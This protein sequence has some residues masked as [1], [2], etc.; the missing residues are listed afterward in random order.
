MKYTSI[1]AVAAVAFATPA[2]AKSMADEQKDVRD[3]QAAVAK[4]DAAIAKQN[5]NI[6]VNRAEKEAAKA[7]GDKM[8]QA[9]QSVQIG[10]N[11]TAKE[12]KKAEK[13]AD[14]KILEHDKKDINEANMEDKSGSKHHATKHHASKHHASNSSARTSSNASRDT[15]Q[16]QENLRV[17]REEKEAAKERGDRIDQASQSAQ[18]G[19]NKAAIAGQRSDRETIKEESP[20]AGAPSEN[21]S[22]NENSNKISEQ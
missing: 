6:A 11:K 9:S 10:A 5:E 2:F 17:N 22:P 21:K 7:R 16:Q 4:D 14:E 1:I 19:A 3:S 18:I 13:S 20:A 15:A 12:A 8:D